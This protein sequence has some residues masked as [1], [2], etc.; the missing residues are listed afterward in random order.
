MK[1]RENR[2]VSFSQYKLWKKCPLAY[3]FQYVDKIGEWKKNI[4]L[5]FGSAMHDTIQ[6][7]L[8]VQYNKRTYS[9]N[10]EVNGIKVSDY[11]IK[12]GKKYV[13][14]DTSRLLKERMAAEVKDIDESERSEIVTKDELMEFYQDGVFILEYLKK[15]RSDWFTIRGW[16]LEG[17]EVELKKRVQDGLDFVGYIDILLKDP[18]D[19]YHIIDLKTSTKGWGFYHKRDTVTTNQNVLYKKYLSE[20]LDI[21]MDK[22]RIEYLILKRKIPSDPDWPAQ[23]RRLQRFTPSNGIISVNRAVED[24]NLFVESV[25]TDGERD[26]TKEFP[27]NPTKFNCTYCEFRDKGVCDY[28]HEEAKNVD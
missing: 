3:K 21:S 17:I 5:I 24:F 9:K 6:A 1:E 15:K 23:A 4:H 12:D 20:K 19:N 14:F 7:Y 2:K 10:D 27:A 13:D 11:V 18:L 28:V 8:Y 22:I 26:E 25:F 16:K